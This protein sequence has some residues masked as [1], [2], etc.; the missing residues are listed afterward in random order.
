V[1]KPFKKWFGKSQVV[2]PLGNPLK[3]YHGTT[4]DF[5]S[6][7][8]EHA[9]PEND[10]GKGIYFTNDKDDVSHN[11]AGKGPDLTNKIETRTEQ[12][13]GEGMESGDA[14]TRANA[15]HM[16]HRGATVPAYLRMENPAVLGGKHETR[17]SHEYKFEDDDPEKDIIGEKGSLPE[18]TQHLR[19]AASKYDDVGTDELEKAIAQMREHGDGLKISDAIEILHA[20]T[21]ALSDAQDENGKMVGNEIIRDALERT[22]YDGII[23]RTVNKKFGSERRGL[24][25]PMRGM[26]PNTVHYIIF[27]PNQAKSAIGNSGKFSNTNPDITAKNN[28]QQSNERVA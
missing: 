8:T 17:L 6:F 1:S 3:V 15:E 20:K 7:D 5:K 21:G 27:H 13:I 4:R 18:F 11:Y 2:D 28:S 14:E 16:Q 24:G 9:N 22:G 19:N 10:F 26:K 25:K 23:D 12:L